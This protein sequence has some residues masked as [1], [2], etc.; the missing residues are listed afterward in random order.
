MFFLVLSILL[1]AGLPCY[2]QW[3]THKNIQIIRKEALSLDSVENLYH[4]KTFGCL[5]NQI[6]DKQ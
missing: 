1:M 5:Y 4:E 3:K 2:N 6:Y